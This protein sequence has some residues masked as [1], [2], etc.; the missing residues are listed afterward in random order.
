[1]FAEM[2]RHSVAD[3][4]M[5]ITDTEHGPYPF[6]GIPWFRSP[7]GRDCL[8][9][10]LLPCG[11]IPP[12]ARGAL[13]FLEAAQ[14]TAVDPA[15]DAAPG[16]VLHEMRDGEMARLGE[17]PFARYY[18]SVDATPLFIVLAG[19]YFKRTADLETVRALWPHIEA[20]LRWIDT[21]GDADADGFI[22]YC[23]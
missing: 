20:A 23:R 7:F 12:I 2:A 17:V 18:G 6:A 3:L 10:A 4:F 15:R 22:E 5:L 19:E 21:C 9:T 14:A 16:K 1:L 11:S 8:L 13:R